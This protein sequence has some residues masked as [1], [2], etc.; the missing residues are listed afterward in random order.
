MTD[1]E[2]I[3][4]Y[5]T[6]GREEKA[7]ELLLKSYQKKLYWHIRSLVTYHDD[8]DDVLQSTFIKIWKALPGFREESKLY[9]WIYRIAT[10]EA[11][12]FL[13]QRKR[14]FAQR[15]DDPDLGYYDTLVGDEYFDGDSVQKKL[16]EVVEKLPPKQK[17]V[18]QMKYYSNMKYKEISKIL[19]VSVGALKA[20]YHHAVKKIELAF[21]DD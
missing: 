7:F 17:L 18:F 9:T 21:K 5:K 6:K 12:S 13:N 2:I 8:A 10:N 20:S 19:D 14:K 1:R 15:I 4:L 16:I 3:S 11:L